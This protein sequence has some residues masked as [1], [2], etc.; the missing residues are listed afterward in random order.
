MVVFLLLTPTPAIAA[1]WDD[2]A[3]AY[4]A[5]YDLR[6]HGRV[7]AVRQQD[8]HSTCW[9]LAAMGSLESCLLPGSALDLSENHLANFQASRLV[10]EG[11]APSTISAAYVARW[12]GPVLER[13]DP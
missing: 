13:D 2:P 3:R 12:E 5:T 8:H 9:V 1:P 6:D 4:P 7:S 10:Y 11:R